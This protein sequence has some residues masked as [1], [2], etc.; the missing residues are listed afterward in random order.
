MTD[1]FQKRLYAVALVVA[2]L[3]TLAAIIYLSIVGQ[4]VNDYLA[5][6]AGLTIG[7]LLPSPLQTSLGSQ[8]VTV[9]NPPGQPVPVEIDPDAGM[10]SVEFLLLVIAVC[11]VLLT[12][13]ALGVG[14]D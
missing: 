9:A 7:A 4:P 1:I 3:G 10:T 6:L 12:L 5:G 14:L 11:A 13:A 2:A 8:T